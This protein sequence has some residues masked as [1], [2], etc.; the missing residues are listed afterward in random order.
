MVD[1]AFSA[2]GEVGLAMAKME[3]GNRLQTS[4]LEVY[5]GR[6]KL[7]YLVQIGASLERD[8]SSSDQESPDLIFVSQCGRYSVGVMNGK[9]N[10]EWAVW[11]ETRRHMIAESS[12]NDMS[13][14]ILPYGDIKQIRRLCVEGAPMSSQGL[15]TVRVQDVGEFMINAPSGRSIW[16]QFGRNGPLAVTPPSWRMVN[17]LSIGMVLAL[18]ASA[19]ML[20]C[21]GIS[22]KMASSL[23]LGIGLCFN[24]SARMLR[25]EDGSQY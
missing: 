24:A 22:F 13:V 20:R 16:N 11:N 5:R 9:V 12:L 2:R 3:E 23:S 6:L 17:S 21:E 1:H 25:C 10:V 18:R 14:K 8:R 19:T 15:E 4:V 7:G